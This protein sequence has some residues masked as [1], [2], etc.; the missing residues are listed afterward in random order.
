[1]RQFEF[2]VTD[3]EGL[4]AR[5]VG[6]LVK[7]TSGY[8]SDIELEK[9][10]DGKTADAKKMLAV[11]ALCAKKGETLKVTV[12]GEDEEQA[13]EDLKMFFKENT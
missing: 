13:A 1:M 6:M 5:P 12:S 9:Y 2:V 10:S 4:H 8:K 3:A 11:M 7:R